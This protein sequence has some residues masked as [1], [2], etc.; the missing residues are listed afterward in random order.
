MLGQRQSIE[1]LCFFSAR[2]RREGLHH[3]S[4]SAYYDPKNSSGHIARTSQGRSVYQVAIRKAKE[5]LTRSPTLFNKI[6]FGC[7][8]AEANRYEEAKQIFE[9]IRREYP[10]YYIH[11]PY[12]NAFYQEGKILLKMGMAL[13]V[14][15]SRMWF[16]F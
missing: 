6:I 8:L 4:L 14:Y 9:E 2:A 3:L 16:S 11:M 7:L 5:E 10:R 1:R 15:S 13:C 12:Y